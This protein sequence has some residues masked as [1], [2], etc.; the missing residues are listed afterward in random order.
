VRWAARLSAAH[1]A[2]DDG[3]DVDGGPTDDEA[4]AGPEPSLD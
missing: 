4:S 3:Y 1:V 2:A